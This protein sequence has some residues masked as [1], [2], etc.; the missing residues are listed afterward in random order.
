MS[1]RKGK[2]LERLVAVI[3][4][5]LND[6][7]SSTVES[8]KKLRDR[9]TGRLREHDVVITLSDGHH[10]V[11]ISI[12]CRDRSR[13]VGVPEVEAFAAKCLD[14]NVNQAVIVSS[15]GFRKSALS[16]AEHLG[17][18]CLGLTE[19]ESV[20]WLLA[21]NFT[22]IRRR[23]I[24]NSWKF[25]PKK[26]GVVSKETLEIVAPDGSVLDPKALTANALR[27]LQNVVSW[28]EGPVN[29][30]ELK[31]RVRTDGFKLRDSATGKTVATKFVDLTIKYET[32]V[33]AMPVKISQYHD[34]I[35]GSAITDV[36]KADFQA[37]EHN[38]SMVIAYKP[39]EGGKVVIVRNPNK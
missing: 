25:C 33:E 13:P 17:V 31:F 2:A 5:V 30:T 37:G 4:N 1:P 15:S 28:N 16:K 7:S 11:L 8:P 23:L 6:A 29:E 19:L 18:R 36:A 39:E 9:T 20:P 34:Q 35:S 38:L 27:I 21:R 24:A 10:S 26:D 22:S 32:I 3:E 12:E 14:T